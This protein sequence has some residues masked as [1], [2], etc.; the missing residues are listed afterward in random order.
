MERRRLLRARF[1]QRAEG[2]TAGRGP[3]VKAGQ[4]AR[5][6]DGQKG[7]GLRGGVTRGSRK[8]RPRPAG[9]MGIGL[10]CALPQSGKSS[11]LREGRYRICRSLSV[12]L[13]PVFS[14]ESC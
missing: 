12:F 5:G 9:G 4:L 13:V 6:G 7:S 2:G 3:C 8:N 11:S 1:L 10:E 14:E